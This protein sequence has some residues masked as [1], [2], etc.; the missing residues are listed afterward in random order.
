MLLDSG[1]HLD[2][3][4]ADVFS[5]NVNVGEHRVAEYFA[6]TRFEL[7]EASENFEKA[8]AMFGD[9]HRSITGG[10]PGAK[11]DGD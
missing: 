6:S 7:V 3:F 9:H 1:P 8:G 5:A 11:S 2:K 4:L 10:A